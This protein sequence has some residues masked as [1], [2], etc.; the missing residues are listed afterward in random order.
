[1]EMEKAKDIFPGAVFGNL[2]FV[3]EG[4]GYVEDCILI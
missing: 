4:D 2:S 3:G 1:M